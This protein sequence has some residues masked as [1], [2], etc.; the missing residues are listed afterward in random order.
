MPAMV[1]T[2]I[3]HSDA[4]RLVDSRNLRK[5]GSMDILLHSATVLSKEAK[6]PH[7][8]I[9][10]SPYP[11]GHGRTACTCV[12]SIPEAAAGLPSPLTLRGPVSCL[13]LALTRGK[14]VLSLLWDSFILYSLTLTLS[15]H[16][17]SVSQLLWLCN[18]Q[19]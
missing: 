8:V 3:I 19:R 6:A 17:S 2:A 14:V 7:Q 9:Q 1:L 5:P 10:H 4:I 13:H 12:R 16:P 18:D 15:S 11:V